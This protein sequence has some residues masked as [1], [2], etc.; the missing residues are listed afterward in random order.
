MHNVLPAMPRSVCSRGCLLVCVC[1][2]AH[3]PMCTDAVAPSVWAPLPA[4]ERST[5]CVPH[6]SPLHHRP[7]PPPPN[8][9]GVGDRVVGGVVVG[10]HVGVCVVRDGDG[11]SDGWWWC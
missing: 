2:G 11:V 8:G 6:A 1:P 9:G 5:C 7:H 3:L 4:H 10:G